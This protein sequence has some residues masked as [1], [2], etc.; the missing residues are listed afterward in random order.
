MICID[1]YYYFD[2]IISIFKKGEYFMKYSELYKTYYNNRKLYEEIYQN[3]FHNE[4]TVMVPFEINHYNCYFLPNN[5]MIQLISKIYRYNRKLQYLES[6]LPG[7]AKDNFK[8]NALIEEIHLSNEMEGIKSTRKEIKE[9][10]NSSK[11]TE[12]NK[13]LY[14]LVQKYLMLSEKEDLSLNTCSDIRKIYDELLKEEITENNPENLPDGLFFRKDVVHVQNEHMKIIHSGLPSE[15]VIIEA[16]Q[17]ALSILHDEEIEPLIRVSI[18]H[19]LF[20]Y[21]HPFY[22]GNGRTVRFLSS[23]YLARELDPLVSYN[24]SFT[25]KKDIKKY[26]RYF[27]ITNDKINRGELTGFILYFLSVILLAVKDLAEKLEEKVEQ[28][29][30]Y[31]DTLKN[32]SHL[33]DKSKKIL[34]ILIQSSLFAFENISVAQISSILNYSNQT[35]YSRFKGSLK[36]YILKTASYYSADLDALDRFHDSE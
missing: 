13:R 11:K 22:D 34:Y 33:D 31:G 36:D 1:F 26:Y 28:L 7:V 16:M 32:M 2:M 8:M 35:I 17:K 29:D 18:F 6:Y 12:S 27:D 23:Y 20:G 19:Y 30:F 14:G 3:R 21:I 4:S 5:E 10:L 15:D 25:I 9:T 24:L